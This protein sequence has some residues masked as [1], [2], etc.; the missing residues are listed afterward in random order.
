[1]ASKI[2][3]SLRAFLPGLMKTALE[4]TAA[5]EKTAAAAALAAERDAK[6]AVA[7]DAA[8]EKAAAAADVVA[9]RDAKLSLALL[10]AQA[11]T[12]LTLIEEAELRGLWKGC[13]A[14]LKRQF[15]S[16]FRHGEL[17]NQGLCLTINNFEHCMF[18]RLVEE[19]GEPTA[20]INFDKA[21]ACWSRTVE[22]ADVLLTGGFTK[23]KP[24]P[25]DCTACGLNG[26][27]VNGHGGVE[28]VLSKGVTISYSPHS[29]TLRVRYQLR[30]NCNIE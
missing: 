11:D 14:S 25:P 9:R 1:M 2:I 21:S 12:W 18:R 28:M 10:Q 15:V 24:C 8:A 4:K 19:F 30:W 5:V 22:S 27:E 29:S 16:Q 7:A 6:L 13:C 23:Q 17:E 20:Q 26:G 3:S